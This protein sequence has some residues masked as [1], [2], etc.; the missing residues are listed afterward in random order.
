MTLFEKA[1]EDNSIFSEGLIKYCDGERD[2]WTLDIL[3]G[4]PSMEYGG[5]SIWDFLNT[6]I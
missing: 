2:Q 6:D 1:A 5:G 4:K 3:S